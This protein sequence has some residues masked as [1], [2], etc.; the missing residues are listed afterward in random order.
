VI[1]QQANNNALDK[2]GVYSGDPVS[3]HIKISP[4]LTMTFSSGLNN[5]P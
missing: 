2:A 1:V 3:D 4:H 5:V